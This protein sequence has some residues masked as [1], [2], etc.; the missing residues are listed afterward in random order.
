MHALKKDNTGSSENLDV[1]VDVDVMQRISLV[2]NIHSTLRLLFDN[3]DNVYGFV[4]MENGND[5]LMVVP[6]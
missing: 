1:D 2:L 4:G 5:F 6:R 3:P